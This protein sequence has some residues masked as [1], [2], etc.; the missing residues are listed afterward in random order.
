LSSKIFELHFVPW[1]SKKVLTFKKNK[2]V[3]DPLESSTTLY[4]SLSSKIFE[5]HFV[6]WNSKKVL[7]SKKVFNPLEST[8]P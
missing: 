5:L 3:F 6:P 4:N 2:K 1:N 7:T 8:T